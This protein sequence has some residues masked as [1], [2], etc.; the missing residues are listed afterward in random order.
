MAQHSP[1]HFSTLTRAERS[2]LIISAAG[3][4]LGMVECALGIVALLQDPNPTYAASGMNPTLG[5]AMEAGM[6]LAVAIVQWWLAWMGWGALKNNARLK[7]LVITN[8]I[9][10]AFCVLALLGELAQTGLSLEDL[11]FIVP[12]FSFASAWAVKRQEANL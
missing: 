1:V 7:P 8:G 4:V 6:Y 3:A 11:A 12:I 2:L 5:R 10:A 9:I